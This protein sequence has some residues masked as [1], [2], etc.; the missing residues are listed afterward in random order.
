MCLTLGLFNYRLSSHFLPGL[1]NVQA[2]IPPTIT[3]PMMNTIDKPSMIYKLLIH[4]FPDG[5]SV[6]IQKATAMAANTVK[7]NNP[8][9]I[10]LLF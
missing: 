4:F 2:Y 1:V 5:V 9:F 6:Y 8:A 3:V 10:Y 7:M